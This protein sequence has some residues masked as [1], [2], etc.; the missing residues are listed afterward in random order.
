MLHAWYHRYS[1]ASVS[2]LNTFVNISN[3][4]CSHKLIKC[5]ELISFYGS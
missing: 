2:G 3:K 4:I 1:D 5:G